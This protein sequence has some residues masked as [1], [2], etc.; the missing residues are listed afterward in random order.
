MF[1]VQ[2]NVEPKDVEVEFLYSDAPGVFTFKVVIFLKGIAI[3]T[4]QFRSEIETCIDRY[5]KEKVHN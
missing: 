1:A 2:Y 3:K 4:I 5:E